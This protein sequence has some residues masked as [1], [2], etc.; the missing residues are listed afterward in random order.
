M[1]KLIYFILLIPAIAISCGEDLLNVSFDYPVETSFTIDESI[2]ANDLQIIESDVFDITV[3]EEM[4]RRNL[5]NVE[6]VK[7][8]SVKLTLPENSD[9]DWSMLTSLSLEVLL[10]GESIEIAALTPESVIN[11]RHISLD[12]YEDEITLLQLLEKNTAQARLQVEVNTP[13]SPGLEIEAFVDM[14]ITASAAE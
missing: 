3:L 11:D 8:K 14:T 1:K 10:D 13:V 2:A 5:G 6:G 12:L 4:A 7:L 9:Y